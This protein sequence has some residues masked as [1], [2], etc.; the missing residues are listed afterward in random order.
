MSDMIYTGMH[1]PTSCSMCWVRGTC[2]EWAMEL[3]KQRGHGKRLDNC[4]L[5]PL[6][7]CKDCVWYVRS[8][9]KQDGTLDKRY[10]PDWCDL[11][12][13]ERKEMYFCADGEREEDD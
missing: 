1:I 13:R 7:R 8:M 3:H 9:I 6:V 11:Y 5:R 12:R 4:P 2:E 10:K